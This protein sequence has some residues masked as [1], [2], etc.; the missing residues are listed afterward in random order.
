MTKKSWIIFA[1]ACVVII[2][3]LV[4][5]SRQD[6]ADVETVDASSIVEA[7]DQ[8]GNIGDRVLGA[9]DAKVVI[10]E[11]GDYQCPG[12][13]AAAPALKKVADDYS[14][15]VALVFRNFPI[16]SAHPNALAAASAA[17]AAGHQGKFWEMHEKLYINQTAWQNLSGANRTEYFMNAAKDLDLDAERL[18]TDIEDPNIR[19][20]I[21]FDTAL[22]KKQ[23][24]AGTPTIFVNGDRVSDWRVKDGKVRKDGSERESLYVWSSPENFEKYVIIPALNAAGVST[25]KS[26]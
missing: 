6:K 20:K 17:E 24:V 18:R 9:K 4:Y 10:F 7:S 12:C 25:E 3:G 1:V 11:Y 2:G 13:A 8:N 21:N 14:D 26:E 22:A 19:K 16:V 15:K 5:F 23:G